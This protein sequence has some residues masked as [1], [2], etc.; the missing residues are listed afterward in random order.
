VPGSVP[1]HSPSATPTGAAVHCDDSERGE[2]RA[3]CDPV[4][5]RRAIL[6]PCR[7]IAA[8]GDPA[9]PSRVVPRWQQNES[10]AQRN[11]RRRNL[12]APE[13]AGV[14]A[15]RAEPLVLGPPPAL[16]ASPRRVFD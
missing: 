7:C 6:T 2:Q 11:A 14:V 1:L 12:G 8:T 10:S 16:T 4:F 15:S 3:L 13:A 9:H 5:G